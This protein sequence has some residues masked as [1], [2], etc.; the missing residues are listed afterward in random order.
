[1]TDYIP[2][3]L[4]AADDYHDPEIPPA[5][6]AVCGI[7]YGRAWEATICYDCFTNA[8]EKAESYGHPRT[9]WQQ[10]AAPLAIEGA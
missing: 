4:I 7:T 2:G 3:N 9:A 10:Y 8:M 6:C 5:I 1:M